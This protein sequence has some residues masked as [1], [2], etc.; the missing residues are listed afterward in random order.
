MLLIF[1]VIYLSCFIAGKRGINYDPRK[2]ELDRIV[3]C[4]NI[5]CL[6]L[7][8]NIKLPHFIMECAFVFIAFLN[9]LIF[10]IPLSFV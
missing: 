2:V 3:L 10:F 5:S 8:K 6:L 4:V 7:K 1:A 9:S